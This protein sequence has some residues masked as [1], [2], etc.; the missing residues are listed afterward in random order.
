MR[1]QRDRRRLL[2]LFRSQTNPT[3]PRYEKVIYTR[4][5][6]FLAWGGTVSLER[7]HSGPVM[8][9]PLP[10]PYWPSEEEDHRHNMRL[11]AKI[12]TTVGEN[13]CI[14][15]MI[16]WDPETCSLAMEYPENG[17]LKEYIQQNTQSI[18]LQRRLQWS[19]QAA[20]SLNV[21]HTHGVI[22]CDLS[23][24]LMFLPSFVVLLSCSVGF[25]R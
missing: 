19:R 24:F 5:G 14:P 16:H 12:Y 4:K 13:P 20:E 18:T 25:D 7:L 1:F 3:E 6:K 22:H 9:T 21:L 8:K 11:E 17:N 23:P 2:A 15:R 10:N